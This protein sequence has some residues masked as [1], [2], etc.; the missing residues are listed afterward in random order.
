MRR[1]F[2]KKKQNTER[3]KELE[4]PKSTNALFLSRHGTIVC[5]QVLNKIVNLR[6]EPNSLKNFLLELSDLLKD[7]IKVYGIHYPKEKVRNYELKLSCIKKYPILTINSKDPGKHD[8]D[9]YLGWIGRM[10]DEDVIKLASSNIPWGGALFRMTCSDKTKYLMTFLENNLTYTQV[11]MTGF[12]NYKTNLKSF[13]FHI[14]G[15]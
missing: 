3:A 2:K 9:I 14:S 15:I 4:F 6:L 8:T 12:L 1:I 11:K 13:K 5:Q 10:S 7:V